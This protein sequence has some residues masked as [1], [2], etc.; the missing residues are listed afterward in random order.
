MWKESAT[1]LSIDSFSK[2]FCQRSLYS[3]QTNLHVLLRDVQRGN[4]AQHFELTAG[5]DEEVPL[6]CCLGDSPRGAL[7]NRALELNSHHQSRGADVL[8]R[9]IIFGRNVLQPGFQLHRP[10]SHILQDILLLKDVQHCQSCGAGHCV[11]SVGASHGPGGLLVH[12]LLAADNPRQRQTVGNTLGKDQHIGCQI[13]KPLET[14]HL[15]GTAES[16]LNVVNDEQNTVLLAD[17]LDT[18]QI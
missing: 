7:R 11:A 17:L 15:A 3:F 6:E 8:D 9:Q 1:Q 18:P 4:E 10:L 16:C 2:N 13:L 14:E 5:Q 12:Q